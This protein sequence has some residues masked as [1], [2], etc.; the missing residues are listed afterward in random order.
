VRS[1]RPPPRDAVRDDRRGK[2][3]AGDPLPRR[4]PSLRRSRRGAALEPV[5]HRMLHAYTLITTISRRSITTTS[6]GGSPRVIGVRRSGRDPRRTA[7]DIG[8]RAARPV[9]RAP[10][11]ASKRSVSSRRAAGSRFLVGGQV[12]D[13]EGEGREATEERV[14]FI[15]SRKTAELIA[16]SLSIGRCLAGADGGTVGRFT[17][18]AGRPAS[19]FRS[20]M[21]SSISRGA[22]R[23]RKT[24]RKERKGRRSPIRPASALKRPARTARRPDRRGARAM[25]A[26]GDDGY[27]S[28]IFSLIVQPL[29]LK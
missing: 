24:L 22:P 14:R 28:H 2:A 20:S 23:R 10:A 1:R 27:V 5:R 17:R 9:R 13:L 29:I 18:S 4:T 11:Q 19:R 6:G 25:E 26:L 3:A 16:A 12:A 21:I 8:L 7:P 15:H